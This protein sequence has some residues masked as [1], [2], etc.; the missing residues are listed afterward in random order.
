MSSQELG[1]RETRRVVYHED[2]PGEPAAAASRESRERL[3]EAL[4]AAVVDDDDR[5]VRGLHRRRAE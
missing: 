4:R 5:N 3:E 1:D 2:L